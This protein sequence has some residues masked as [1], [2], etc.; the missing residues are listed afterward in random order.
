[1]SFKLV[2]N[3]FEDLRFKITFNDA[4]GVG[5]SFETPQ[6]KAFNIS[7]QRGNVVSTAS[8]TIRM[9]ASE[10]GAVQPQNTPSVPFNEKF[11]NKSSFA[12]YGMLKGETGWVPLFKGIVKNVTIRRDFMLASTYVVEVQAVD[13]LHIIQERT[14]TRRTVV[15]NGMGVFAVITGVE[16]KSLLGRYQQAANSVIRAGGRWDSSGGIHSSGFSSS[17]IKA[18]TSRKVSKKSK[19]MFVKESSIKKLDMSKSVVSGSGFF[20]FLSDTFGIPAGSSNMNTKAKHSFFDRGAFKQT[21]GGS[22]SV[23]ST[24]SGSGS[25]RIVPAFI[26]LSPDEELNFR[27]SDATVCAPPAEDAREGT[28]Y[29]WSVLNSNYGTIIDGPQGSVIETKDSDFP[30]TDGVWYRHKGIGTQW[31]EIILTSNSNGATGSA[32]IMGLPVHKHAEM[33][34]GGPAYGTYAPISEEET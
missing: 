13:I 20:S 4:A 12:I 19:K 32:T 22:G 16:Q 3:I 1:M 17:S 27:C 25:I 15:E 6:V 29:T 2:A 30:A 34:E 14:Y 23:S 18:P 5:N 28:A 8:A 9:R 10:L 26:M 24:G 7:K 31:N 21:S 33:K 11:N